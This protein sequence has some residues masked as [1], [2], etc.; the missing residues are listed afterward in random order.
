VLTPFSPAFLAPL[1]KL[2]SSPGQLDLTDLRQ[3]LPLAAYLLLFVVAGLLI[4]NINRRRRYVVAAVG[5]VL[6]LALL[7]FNGL[8]NWP[9]WLGASLIFF[10]PCALAGTCLAT[11]LLFAKQGRSGPSMLMFVAAAILLVLLSF[12][13]PLGG[14]AAI[15]GSYYYGW[16]LCAVPPFVGGILL[17]QSLAARQAERAAYVA[18]WL[19]IAG[20]IGLGAYMNLM[21]GITYAFVAPERMF[22]SYASVRVAQATIEAAMA[23]CIYVVGS[24]LLLAWPFTWG[25]RRGHVQTQAARPEQSD[26]NMSKYGETIHFHAHRVAPAAIAAVLF[27]LTWGVIEQAF[28]DL[29]LLSDWAVLSLSLFVLLALFLFAAYKLSFGLVGTPVKAGILATLFLVSAVASHYGYYIATL[30]LG[31]GRQGASLDLG[32]PGAYLVLW[33]LFKTS[34][35]WWLLLAAVGGFGAGWL[36]SR[37]LPAVQRGR[38]RSFPQG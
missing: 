14:L 4:E 1:Y 17:A 32:Q 15:A 33:Q 21:E 3:Q 34:I 11:A 10:V 37:L 26:G 38:W 8:I 22:G 19:L 12:S 20:T 23:T 25:K 28:R 9:G 5:L 6:A 27:G 30:A 29:R 24:L 2:Q 31:L 35:A 13:S 18:L 16:G 36:L 7:Y